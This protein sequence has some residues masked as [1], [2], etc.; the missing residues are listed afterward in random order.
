MCTYVTNEELE[1]LWYSVVMMI[2]T[3]KTVVKKLK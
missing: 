2:V 1:E 3:L